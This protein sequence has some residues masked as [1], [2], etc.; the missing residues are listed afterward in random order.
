MT[1]QFIFFPFTHVTQHQLNTVLA[2]FPAL[3][4]LSV[5]PEGDESKH[6]KDASKAGNIHRISLPEKDLAA[7]NQK[8]LQYTEWA[9]IHKG[10][11][12][13]LKAIIQ[14][15]A[16][17]TSDTHVSTIKSQIRG[18]QRDSDNLPVDSY[19]KKLL[20]LRMAQLCDEQNEQIDSELEGVDK[21]K[22]ELLIALQGLEN[23]IEEKVENNSVAQ[24]DAGCVMT[25]ERIASWSSVMASSRR[26]DQEQGMRF[27][28][29]TSPAV[30]DYLESNST[31]VVN[32]LDIDQIKVH[33]N[34][35][36]MKAEWQHQFCEYLM[37]SVHE[38]ESRESGLP[39]MAGCCSLSGQIKLCLFSGDMI[40]T[41]LNVSEKQVAVCLVNLK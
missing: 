30:F 9:K 24:N 3:N 14:D 28:V 19:D 4:Y 2:F 37:R 41:L 26:L 34:N 1:V 38:E 23:P 25:G 35:C 5:K 18:T 36:E 8:V 15:S 27:F 10:N 33:E 29:T 16:Y 11:E 12:H 13:N 7:L 17:F 22:K 21:R 6:L 20:F 31:D 32:A 40:N 39:E